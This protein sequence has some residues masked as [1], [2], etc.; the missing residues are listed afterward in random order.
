MLIGDRHYSPNVHMILHLP[1]A[2]RN[3]GPLWAHSTFPF[4]NMNGWLNDLYHGT[5]DPQKQVAVC[6]ARVCVCVYVLLR[7]LVIAHFQIVKA[8][9]EHQKLRAAA[10]IVLHDDDQN[11]ASK[12]F[13]AHTFR[14]GQR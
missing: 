2:V 7:I 3:L 6:V 5:R 12:E 9:L 1:D 8:V 11:E 14:T 10:E 4:E 13:L